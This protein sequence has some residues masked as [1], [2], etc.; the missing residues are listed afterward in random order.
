MK[1]EETERKPELEPYRSGHILGAGVVEKLCLF[2][3]R[4]VSFLLKNPNIFQHRYQKIFAD[5]SA[6]YL[7]LLTF[8]DSHDMVLGSSGISRRG[9]NPLSRTKPNL[10][11]CWTQRILETPHPLRGFK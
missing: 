5:N 7:I 2:C 8:H 11:P 9:S 1:A 4:E 10:S 6:S 3:A